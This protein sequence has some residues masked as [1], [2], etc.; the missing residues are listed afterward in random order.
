MVAPPNKAGILANFRSSFGRIR[1]KEAFR[2]ATALENGVYPAGH[3]LLRAA[4]T[5]E[6][7]LRRPP[8]EETL[9]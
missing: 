9:C 8:A 5:A 3:I 4:R 2:T 7:D 1:T 6:S